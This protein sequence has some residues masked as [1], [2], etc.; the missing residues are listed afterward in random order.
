MTRPTRVLALDD[1]LTMRK[2]VGIVFKDTAEFTLDLAED[3]AEG[4]ALARQNRPD[5]ILLDYV[6][7]DLRGV[8]VCRELAADENLKSV[9]LLVTS[10]KGPDI[11][12]E[13]E[14]YPNAVGY[15]GKPFKP[16]EL[17]RRAR[18]VLAR[19]RIVPAAPASI[20]AASTANKQD[21]ARALYGPLKEQFRQ[22]PQWYPALGTGRPDLFFAK[23]ILT[24]KLVDELIEALE[25]LFSTP[26]T[27]PR[28]TTPAPANEDAP[29]S[30]ALEFLPLPALLRGLADGG[31]TGRL[32]LSQPDHSIF[33]YLVE[34]RIQAAGHDRPETN[35]SDGFAPPAGTA[36]LDRDQADEAQRTDGTPPMIT[37][38]Q[39]GTLPAAD[40]SKQLF[41]Y[42]RR[43]ISRLFETPA[44]RFRWE[45][46]AAAPAWVQEQG[47]EYSIKL[48]T[49]EA[50]RR[51][52]DAAE[53]EKFIGNPER[54]WRRGADFSRQLR[55]FALNDHERR[56]LTLVDNRN[57]VGRVTERSGLEV[58]EVHCLLQRMAEVDLIRPP[59]ETSAGLAMDSGC[60]PRVLMIREPDDEGVVQPLSDLLSQRHQPISVVSLSDDTNVLQ[61]LA[62]TRPR[63]L[64]LNG[65]TPDFDAKHLAETVRNTLELS[66]LS[67]VVILEPEMI[68]QYD[69]Y[70][71]AGFDQVLVKPFL[72]EELEQCLLGVGGH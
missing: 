32:V 43:V 45:P 41:T 56:V 39:Q 54:V 1:S 24:P 15:V 38:M 28:S 37:L 12:K 62:E 71:K 6:L 29:L 11:M 57:S 7:P 68:D 70:A 9:P 23:R 25:P 64:A 18:E 5:I 55:Q 53:A 2:L 8:D 27:S 10:A 20:P 42:T 33:L 16:A 61:R 14:P 36:A 44:A 58:S 69:T 47:K 22:I 31:G 48:L 59:D 46:S 63:V 65:S 50:S 3:G 34:G 52:R 51:N 40:S 21:I 17:L 67:L 66:D 72:A 19:G 60:D 49:W 13:F 30:G 26:S 4:L 35:E